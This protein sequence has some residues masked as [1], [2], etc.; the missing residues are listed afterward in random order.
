MGPM[1]QP[2]PWAHVGR[3]PRVGVPGARGAQRPWSS[4]QQRESRSAKRGY[5]WGLFPR[6]MDFGSYRLPWRFSSCEEALC[7]SARQMLSRARDGDAITSV[8]GGR[9]QCWLTG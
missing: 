6:S 8:L 5:S 2:H 9:A 1:G 3:Q 4:S 7:P